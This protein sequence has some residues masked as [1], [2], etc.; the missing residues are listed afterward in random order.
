MSKLANSLEELLSTFK[1]LRNP[2]TGCPW[3]REQ[4]FK[5]IASCAI[6]EAYE[7]ADV[8]EREDWPALPEELA[9]L[10]FQVVFYAQLGK[11]KKWAASIFCILSYTQRENYGLEQAMS[12]CDSQGKELAYEVEQQSVNLSILK[13]QA[14]NSQ[15]W[16]VK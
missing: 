1:K 14:Q 5:S 2:D 10:L 16:M 3:D 9:D 15:F 7:V 12:T 4:D 11:E 13:Q 6:E 8:I